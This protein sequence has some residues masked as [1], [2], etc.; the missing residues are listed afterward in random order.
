MAQMRRLRSKL[1]L[2]QKLPEYDKYG[3]YNHLVWP[4]VLTTFAAAATKT[5]TVCLGT[6][7]VPTY[8]RHPLG[9]GTAGSGFI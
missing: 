9:P 6:S 2:Q 4:D 8:P 5:S 1:S 7:I 3:W